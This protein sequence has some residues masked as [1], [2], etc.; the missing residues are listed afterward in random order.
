MNI[1]PGDMPIIFTDLDGTLLDHESYGYEPAKPALDFLEKKK[2]PLVLNSSKTLEEISALKAQ[3]KNPH[4]VISENGSVV[5]VADGYFSKTLL[6]GWGFERLKGQWVKRLGGLRQELLDTLST[7]REEKKY[8]FT[9]FADM[10]LS[11]LCQHTGL[12]QASAA[13]AK[14][15]LS[16]E[17]ILWQGNESQWAD[18]AADLEAADL[19]WVQGGRF[20][21]ISRPFDKRDGVRL[22]MELYELD[23][24]GPFVTIGLGDS[25]ND[26][27][28]LNIMDMAVVVN[29]T[30]SD[31]IQLDRPSDKIIRTLEPGPKGWYQAIREIFE[32]EWESMESR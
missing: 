28:V 18:F 11:E 22:L 21:S 26:Q 25:P 6:E 19:A 32:P 8:K 4:P 2:I 15:R 16:T 31:Q 30:R 20:I 24:R 27:A 17:P 3:M 14:D 10:T 1:L 7:F 5:G 9:G 29:S 12:S 13:L 23:R